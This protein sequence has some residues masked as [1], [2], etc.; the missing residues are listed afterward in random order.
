MGALL[1]EWFDLAGDP[2]TVTLPG[3]FAKNG[4][5]AVQPLP[6]DA[7]QVLRVYLEGRP[8]GVPIWPGLATSR[9]ADM[10]KVDLET[11]GIPYIV[12][13]PDGPLHADFHALRHS[14]IAALDRAGASLKEAM[15]LAR[16]GDPRL[17]MAVY[18]RAPTQQLGEV[19]GRLTVSGQDAASVQLGQEQTVTLCAY[20]MCLLDLLLV[21]PPVALSGAT[22]C[23]NLTDG[24]TLAGTAGGVVNPLKCNTLQHF[25]RLHLAGLEPATFGSV[26]RCEKTA[27]DEPEKSCVPDTL[28]LHPPLHRKAG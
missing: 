12:D 14:F 23:N 1:P 5:T 18:G 16:H 11:A 25:E 10:L 17:T 7:A 13:G 24:D 28:Q 2:P 19:V 20:L 15:Q 9:P 22:W 6:A 21:A 3:E 8:A 26:D 27:T 4:R